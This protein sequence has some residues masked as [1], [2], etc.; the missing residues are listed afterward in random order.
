MSKTRVADWKAVPYTPVRGSG[1][2]LR[3]YPIVIYPALSAGVLRVLVS[4]Q[5]KLVSTCGLIPSTLKSLPLDRHNYC[6]VHS[7]SFV[8]HYITH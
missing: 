1:F 8:S 2:K 6:S 5:I 4:S 7:H 3:F